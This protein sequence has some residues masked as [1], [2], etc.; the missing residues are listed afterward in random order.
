MY[1]NVLMMC[2]LYIEFLRIV[3]FHFIVRVLFL[4]DSTMQNEAGEFIDLYIPRKW[5][6]VFVMRVFLP[7]PSVSF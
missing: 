7:F 3:A 4:S 6:V 2:T 1:T 5:Y